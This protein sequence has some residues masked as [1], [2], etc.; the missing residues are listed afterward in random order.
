MLAIEYSAKQTK[1]W[2]SARASDTK[3]NNKIPGRQV[4]HSVILGEEK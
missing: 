4:Q 2:K 1:L 3:V